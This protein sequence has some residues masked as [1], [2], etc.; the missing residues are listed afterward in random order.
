MCAVAAAE[1]MRNPYRR[2]PTG[3]ATVRWW[4]R[5]R[6]PT[7]GIPL[8]PVSG[9]TTLITITIPLRWAAE[10]V[11]PERAYT[12]LNQIDRKSVV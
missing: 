2:I 3:I 10:N 9:A 1:A 7:R 8:I 6:R 12:F 4:Y 11:L 5:L